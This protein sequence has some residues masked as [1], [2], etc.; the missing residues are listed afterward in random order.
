MGWQ[1]SWFGPSGRRRGESSAERQVQRDAVGKAIVAN[2][3][4]RK[5][6]IEHSA[7]HLQHVQQVRRARLI[8]QAS[9]PE[10]FGV[11]RQHRFEIALLVGHQRFVAERALDLTEGAQRRLPEERQDRKSTRL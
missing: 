10:R 7:L 9:E 8:S 2:S 3:D 6:R 11:L 5:L 1:T 4:E